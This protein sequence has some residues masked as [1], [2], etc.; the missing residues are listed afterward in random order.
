MKKNTK[1]FNQYTLQSGITVQ[2]VW[3]ESGRAQL[4]DKVTLSDSDDPKRWWEVI[5]VYE[6]ELQKS[7]IKDS[8]D[9]K[10][11][12]EKDHRTKL[13]GLNL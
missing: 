8:H 2:M 5:E 9:S 4:G 7:D 13:E 1:T 11:W 6:A 10:K 12:F 3:L